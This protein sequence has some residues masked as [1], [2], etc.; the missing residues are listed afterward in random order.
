MI[1]RE[2]DRAKFEESVD[3]RSDDAGER[4]KGGENERKG[5]TNREKRKNRENGEE[6][7]KRMKDLKAETERKKD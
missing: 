1:V 4:E 3:M 5:M 2:N 7:P 6:L